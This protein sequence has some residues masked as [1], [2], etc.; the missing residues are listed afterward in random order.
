MYDLWTHSPNFCS[1]FWDNYW[2]LLSLLSSLKTFKTRQICEFAN[3]FSQISRYIVGSMVRWSEGSFEMYRNCCPETIFNAEFRLLQ[4]LNGQTN[5]PKLKTD[6]KL[7]ILLI[8]I[9]AWLFSY[10]FNSWSGKH[11]VEGIIFFSAYN[12][13]RSSRIYKAQ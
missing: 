8:P 9:F 11:H 13:N 6:W 7:C 3:C 2:Y 1:I 12:Y 4:I 5:K 10:A